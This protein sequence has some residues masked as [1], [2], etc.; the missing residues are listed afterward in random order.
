[1][2][3]YVS[4]HVRRP[5]GM[6]PSGRRVY[7][8]ERVWL[9]PSGHAVLPELPAVGDWVAVGDQ[10][11]RVIA[12]QWEPVAYGSTV[13]PARETA[14]PWVPATVILEPAEEGLFADEELDGPPP[15][16]PRPDGH[17][18]PFED[19]LGGAALRSLGGSGLRFE[20][21]PE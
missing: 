16:T 20:P 12:R 11:G 17:E 1:M 18:M 7:R 15:P 6:L 2:N 13:W 9:H 10:Y 3:I 5:A 8:Y 21:H 14:P 19:A 4:F